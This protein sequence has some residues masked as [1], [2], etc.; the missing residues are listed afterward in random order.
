MQNTASRLLQFRDLMRW[1]PTDMA[2]KIGISVGAYYKNENGLT[3]PNLNSLDHM[4]RDL[5]ISMDWFIFNKG[6]MFYSEKEKENL[7]VVSEEKKPGIQ[8]IIPDVQELWVYKR[9]CG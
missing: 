8:E 6:P 2:S 1:S 7:P 3:F 4:Q 5:N 9:I